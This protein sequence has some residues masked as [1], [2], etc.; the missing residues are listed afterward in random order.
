MPQK[1][2]VAILLLIGLFGCFEPPVDFPEGEIEGYRPIY[3]SEVDE[4]VSVTTSREIVNPGQIYVKGNL[5][6]INEI[7]EGVHLIDNTDLSNPINRGFLR[8]QGSE[9]M[10]LR[11]GILYINQ[12]T[13]VLAIDVNDIQNIQVISRQGTILR[14]NEFESDVPPVTG[15]YFECPDSSKGEV[16]GWQLTTIEDPKCYR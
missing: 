7:G 16:I 6:L 4:S 2:L 8:V 5:L 10:A 1:F 11:D 14:E 13:T 15:Y 12:Y 9:N 3:A